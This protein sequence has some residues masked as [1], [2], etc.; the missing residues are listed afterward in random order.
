MKQPAQAELARNYAPCGISGLLAPITRP[1]L[2]KRAPGAAALMEDWA[3]IVGPEMAARS[4][5]VKLVGGALTIG[6]AG[7]E[8][9]ELQHFAP[10]L[11]SR[12]NLA[13]GREAVTRLRFVRQAGAE[14][15]PEP[16]P[17]PEPSCNV[18]PEPPRE[19]PE[20][21]LGDAL[22]ALY[23]GIMSRRR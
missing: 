10:Q 3:A 11:I 15:E 13:L 8:G 12:I 22:A 1:I 18:A 21:E 9:L 17:A 14:P 19:L 16:D 20:G 4:H 2:R 23:R 7:P 6:C 5:P